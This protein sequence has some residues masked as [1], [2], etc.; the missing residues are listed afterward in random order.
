MALSSL[1]ALSDFLN[2]NQAR[3]KKLLLL[4]LLGGSTS[5]LVYTLRTTEPASIAV[6]LTS[7]SA[8]PDPKNEGRATQKKV[9]VDMVFFGRLWKILHI[10]FPSYKSKE[11]FYFIILSGLLLSRTALTIVIAEM[12]GRNA[13]YLVA[14]EWDQMINGILNFGLIVI[15]ASFINAA[16]KYYTGLVALHTRKRLS[17]HVHVKYLDGVNFYKASNLGINKIVNADQRVTA[18]IEKFS[19]EIADLYTS[20]FKPLLDVLLFTYKLIEI[21]GWQ[22][23]AIMYSYFIFSGYVKRIV[24][25]GFGRMVARLS[26]LE[27]YYRTAHQR[28]LANSEEI[29]FYDGSRK[30]RKLINDALSS[31]FSYNKFYLYLNSLINTFDSIYV[32]YYASVAGY[33]ALASPLIFGN[34]RQRNASTADLTRDYIRNSQYLTNLAGAVGDIV[35]VGNKLTSIAGYTSRV[36]ELL[37]SVKHLNEAGNR[38][39]EIVP[40]RTKDDEAEVEGIHEWIREWKGRCDDQRELRIRVRQSSI[41][42][43]DI[44]GGGEIVIGEEIKFSH[45]DI[46]SP[47]GK[48]LVKDLDFCVR[49]GIN[50]MVTG[51]NGAGKSS[52]FRVIG[53]LW[54]L[55]N[56][57]LTKP[58]KE[59]ILFVPQKP[60][61]VLGTLRDQIIYP[62]TTEDMKSLGVTDADLKQLLAIVDPQQ[63]I[64]TD[65]DWDEV[66]DW[67]YAFS[68]GQKQ[69][70]A[71]ARLFYHRPKFAILDECTSAVS[72]EIEDK[73]YETCKELGITIFTVSHRKILARHHDNV[74]H[75]DGRGGWKWVPIAQNVHEEDD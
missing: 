22:G 12:L 28:L 3:N 15:P 39:F 41:T 69:R 19:S 51:P 25:P 45:V 40:E 31:I 13:Q 71:M 21:L 70:V 57:V 72:D 23:P 61:L 27:G 47:E 60:Y 4:L 20:L 7:E 65:W 52:L 66:R 54:P 5:S 63:K 24:M 50:V 64:T 43:K 11:T 46:V 18:D 1:A 53:E 74:L 10:A 38:P 62:H 49:P 26:E 48:L 35:L 29:A 75:F 17:E 6:K 56:G 8:K 44:H 36:S 37:E 58:R 9:A 68:G 30:E 42:A 59:E 33:I 32:K 73:I 34:E 2:A 16:L 14:R 67:F 55:H